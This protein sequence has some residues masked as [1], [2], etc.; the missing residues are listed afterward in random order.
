MKRLLPLLCVVALTLSSAWTTHAQ[1]ANDNFA[2][3][4]TLTGTAITT[5][6][7]SGQTQAGIPNATK[8]AGEPNHAGLPGG[9]SVWFNWTAPTNG[10]S[11][12][13]TIGSGFNTLLGVYT[14]T[15]VNALTLVAANDNISEGFGGNNASRVEFSAVAG[16][17]YR[18][19]I[20]GRSGFNGQNP[21]SGPY[22][23]HVQVLAS[24]FITTPTN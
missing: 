24:V 19:A 11:R 16:T 1:P 18:I 20:D 22:V 21:A 6:G 3:A 8:E 12:I 23:L 14:G 7:N 4:W 13:D 10:Q 9:R 2:N 17:T 5:N 15:A